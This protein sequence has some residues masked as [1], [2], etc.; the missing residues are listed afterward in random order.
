MTQSA[1]LAVQTTQHSACL[2]THSLNTPIWM[3]ALAQQLALVDQS[4]TTTHGI[5][6]HAPNPV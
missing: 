2:A 4:L 5:V 6:I 1:N 3:A